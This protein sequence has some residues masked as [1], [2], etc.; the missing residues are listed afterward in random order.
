MLVIYLVLWAQCFNEIHESSP[1]RARQVREQSSLQVNSLVK[2]DHESSMIDAGLRLVTKVCSFFGALSE[3]SIRMSRG[4][5]SLRVASQ[6]LSL[7]VFPTRLTA[8]GYPGMSGILLYIHWRTIEEVL[9][10]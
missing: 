5:S 3:T 1:V 7:P 4:T 8:P 10:S 2:E 6:G 9:F